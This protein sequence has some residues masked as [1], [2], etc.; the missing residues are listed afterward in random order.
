ML[1]AV[2]GQLVLRTLRRSFSNFTFVNTYEK[3]NWNYQFPRNF[4]KVA[5]KDDNKDDKGDDK[6]DD[7]GGDKKDDK[8]KNPD[9][10]SYWSQF[11]LMI[12]SYGTF[13][14]AL[15]FFRNYKSNRENAQEQQK[16]ALILMNMISPDDIKHS[17]VPPG[18]AQELEDQHHYVHR[19]ELEQQINSIL[20]REKAD[21]T[22][23]ILYGSKGCGKSIV[24]DKC[25]VGKKG[26]VSV[27]ISSVFDKSAILQTM[28]EEIKGKKASAVTEKELVA[29]LHDAK[30]DGRL[31]TVVFEIERGDAA[32][33]TACI[34]NV[35]SLSKMFAQVCNCI[36][37]LSEA[38]AILVFGQDDFRETYIL[39]PDLSIH[40][41]LEYM[42]ARKGAD[43]DTKEMMRLF[44]SVGTNSSMLLKFVSEEGASV[45]EFIAA[46]LREAHLDLV[47]FALKPILQA[48]KNDPNDEGVSPDYFNN[49]KWEGIDLSNP[50]AVGAA[51]KD[52][53]AIVYDMK[54]KR[55]KLIS[56]A[57]K[58][59]LRK[60]DP[61]YCYYFPFFNRTYKWY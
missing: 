54:E 20:K 13:S 43:V 25:I 27:L 7:K 1:R 5:D 49:A 39:V 42:Q 10:T 35:R 51:T 40:E 24:V 17:C 37:I 14:V 57:H 61:I 41:A 6:K 45:D 44:D 28:T 26:V 21:D 12:L 60:Y 33:Q 15:D 31:A 47:A 53:N 4:S 59:A 50:V 30:V 58:V 38:N 36:I 8:G 29:A 23:F 22:Y 2:R 16:D 11:A 18:R 52:S 3:S 48:L 56:Q 19:T 55:Y 9:N 32:E 34:K 46:K